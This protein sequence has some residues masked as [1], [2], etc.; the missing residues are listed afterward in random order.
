MRLEQ[1][2]P[3]EPLEQHVQQEPLGVALDQTT[4]EL[5]QDRM[6]KAR[7]FQLEAQGVLPIDASTN[8]VRGLAIGQV[9]GELKDPD[10][11]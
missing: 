1:A 5:A 9:L 10:Q 4:A 7:V 11:R 6:V 8:G 3:A 2:Q